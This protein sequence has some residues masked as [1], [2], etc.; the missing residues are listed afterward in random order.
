[1]IER[2]L[3]D[4]EADEEK[5]RCGADNS[6][7]ELIAAVYYLEDRLR[8]RPVGTVCEACKVEAVPFAVD[9]SGELEAEGLLDEAADYR[10]LADRL[11]REAGLDRRKG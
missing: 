5:P 1:M 9:I 4:T 11:A 2:H 7:S 6:D 8:D 10:K 3:S